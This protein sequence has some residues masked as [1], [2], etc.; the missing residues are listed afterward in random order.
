MGGVFKCHHCGWAGYLDSSQAPRETKFV[1]DDDDYDIPDVPFDD[2]KLNAKTLKFF[3]E[4]GISK[5]TLDANFIRSTTWVFGGDYDK[6]AIVFPFF[7]GEDIVQIQFRALEDKRFKMVKGCQQP[8]YGLQHIIEDGNIATKRLIIVEGLI[9]KLALYEVGHKFVLSVPNGSPFE[10]EGK[11]SVNPKLKFMDDPD[12]QTIFEYVD[13]IVFATDNDH[14]GRRL[15][16]EMA[17]RLGVDKC[18]I[19]DWPKGCKDANDVLIQRGVDALLD[20]IANA[21]SFPTSGIIELHDLRDKLYTLHETGITPG[22]STGFRNLDEIFTVKDGYVSCTTGVPEVGKSTFW[23]NISKNIC[24]K[25]DMHCG[26]WSPENR[27]TE[28]HASNLMQLYSGKKFD[29]MT[30]EEL[31]ES[32]EWV[33]AHYSWINPAEPSMV[34]IFELM[35]KLVMKHGTKLFVLDPYASVIVDPKYG[36]EHQFIRELLSRS[37]DFVDKF[38]VHL[39]W[40]AHPTKLTLKEKKREEDVAEWPVPNA[41]NISGSAH[42]FNKLD[43]ILSLWRTNKRGEYPIHVWCQKSKV[44]QVARSRQFRMFTY[45]EETDLYMPFS[46]E[47]DERLDFDEEF[48]A[49]KRM[50]D[51]DDE[52]VEDD[53]PKKRRRLT[54]SKS[55]TQ[56]SSQPT[57]RRIKK[58]Q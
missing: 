28:V 49:A 34:N 20:C 6:P 54:G 9:D 41:Y 14:P 52:Y 13:E 51:D 10:E 23:N 22:W 29:E 35:A 32:Y 18:R 36:S 7:K 55:R 45:D 57:T 58:R 17:K 1:W 30:Q 48:V 33:N 12:A 21:K 39:A 42:W 11:P 43:F 2:W 44:K 31:A 56:N 15:R 27:P 50:A 53:A 19:V 4:R 38:K 16:D 25:Y 40:I 8:F 37:L 47:P 3:K 26:L 5:P 24:Q 46:G